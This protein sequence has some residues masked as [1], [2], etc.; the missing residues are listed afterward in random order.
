MSGRI[1]KVMKEENFASLVVPGHASFS[2]FKL[3]PIGSIKTDRTNRDHLIESLSLPA[4]Q[5]LG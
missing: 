5:D 1:G 2:R 4:V 3:N